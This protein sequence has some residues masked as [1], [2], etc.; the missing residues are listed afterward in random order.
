MNGWGY[1][2]FFVFSILVSLYFLGTFLFNLL[3]NPPRPMK[4]SY[5]ELAALGLTISYFITYLIL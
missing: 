4:I 2:L 3:S 5:L 1:L